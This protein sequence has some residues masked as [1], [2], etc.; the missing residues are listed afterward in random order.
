MRAARRDVIGPTSARGVT[1][2]Y[3]YFP[4]RP[5]DPGSLFSNAPFSIFFSLSCR[6]GGLV[7][8]QRNMDEPFIKRDGHPQCSGEG[9]TAYWP[10]LVEISFS[11]G[12][13]HRS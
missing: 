10:R 5:Y 13:I 1:D 6:L 9:S 2:T 8:Q 4:S 12:R 11:E 7:N 3:A